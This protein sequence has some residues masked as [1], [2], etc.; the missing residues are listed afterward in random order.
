MYYRSQGYRYPR[1]VQIPVNYGGN[2]FLEKENSAEEESFAEKEN[3]TEEAFTEKENEPSTVSDDYGKSEESTKDTEETEQKSEA[4]PTSL[5]Q[6]LTSKSLFGG[7]IGS[8]E[9]L[10][11]ALVFLL[12]DTD[13]DNDIIWLLLLLLFIK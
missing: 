7:R 6:S 8:E 3:D 10:I 1:G 2:A 11:L 12:S 4:A 5:F 9:L 13:S